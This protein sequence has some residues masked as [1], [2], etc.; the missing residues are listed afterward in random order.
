MGP[1]G[2]FDSGVGGLTVLS[3]VLAEFSDISIQ[4]LGDQKHNPY[5]LRTSG[6]IVDLTT[7][8]VT[9]LLD[10]GCPLVIVACNTASAQT[11]RHIQ[12]TV[13][14]TRYPHQ[15]V[16]GVIRP[17]AEA[18]VE[19]TRNGHVGVFATRA[20][21]EARAYEREVHHLL[22]SAEITEIAIPELAGV[23]E[24]GQAHTPQIQ[25]MILSAVHMLRTADPQVDTVLLGC[26][27]FAFEKKFFV[28]A[29]P[30]MTV[31]TQETLIASALGSYLQ[32]HPEINRQIDRTVQRRYDT[33]GD[34]AIVSVV[35]SR[36]FGEAVTFTP[37]PLFS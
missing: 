21:V 15:R 26:T 11:L 10:A 24:A 3:A 23:I 30:G 31:L 2:F 35:A 28:D 12:Q 33:T 18:L 34:P 25:D 29:L 9:F 20:T 16:L 6:D 32:R 1:V 37:S 8:A 27:H 17:G 14:L 4:Y 22:P 7:K 13:L 36:F 19:A 5:G